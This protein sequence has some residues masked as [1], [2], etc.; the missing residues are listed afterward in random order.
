MAKPSCVSHIKVE[1][2]IENHEDI[3]KNI[4]VA[5]DAAGED[6]LF[7]PDFVTSVPKVT[8]A[9]SGSSMA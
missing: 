9:S 6:F 1:E 2:K 5:S 7:R 8:M 3:K 4:V